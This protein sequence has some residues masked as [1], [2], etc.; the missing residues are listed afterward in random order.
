MNN[1]AGPIVQL[2]NVEVRFGKAVVHRHINFSLYRGETVTLLG[3]SGSGKTIILKLIMGLMSATGG[4]I[5]VLGQNITG[6]PESE[7]AKLRERLGM[8]FQGAALFDSLS[9]FENIAY[10]LRARGH[11]DEQEISTVVA[12][13]LEVVGLAGI[14]HKFPAQLSGGQRKR[15]GLARAL[16]SSPEIMLFDE[17]TTGLDPSSRRLIDELIIKMRDRYGLTSLV[18]THDIESA[19]RISNRWV[20]IN[21]GEVI[22]DGDVDR[23]IREDAAVQS[24]VSGS[25]DED[26]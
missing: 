11:R 3:A 23:L 1:S 7:L 2:Q 24:F 4:E 8:L 13:K 6:R 26:Q 9:V 17:P 22:A 20:L 14:Q 18:V 15:V 21:N 25:W 12:E 10:S 19:K 16:A 5:S